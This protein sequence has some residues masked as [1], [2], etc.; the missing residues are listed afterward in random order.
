M[1]EIRING[2]LTR[3]PE[4]YT[5]KNGDS[6]LRFTVASSKRVG[7]TEYTK[8]YGVTCFNAMRDIA[9]NMNLEK[10]DFVEVFGEPKANAYMGKDGT[11]KASIDVVARML[12]RYPK[13]N[14]QQT[15]RQ[16]GGNF[17]QFG[18]A[19]PDEDIPF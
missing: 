15:P 10:G 13:Q 4:E 1:D 5:M 3:N 8:Y 11:P 7:T 6:L 2:N 9:R 16:G 18:Q 17:S 19:R 12:G 14:Q